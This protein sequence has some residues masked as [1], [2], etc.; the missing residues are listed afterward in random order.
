MTSED[1]S[2]KDAL[3][4]LDTTFEEDMESLYEDN[5]LMAIKHI[6]STPELYTDLNNSTVNNDPD[7]TL[8]NWVDI[9]YSWAYMHNDEFGELFVSELDAVNWD[10][11]LERV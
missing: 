8:E 7:A 5:T 9:C 3:F 2:T 1:L 4:A 6:N 10:K 11:V